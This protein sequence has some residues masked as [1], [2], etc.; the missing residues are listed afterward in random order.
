MEQR[1]LQ[2]RCRPCTLAGRQLITSQSNNLRCALLVP[3]CHHLLPLLGSFHRFLGLAALAAFLFCFW[4]LFHS[5][6]AP[7]HRRVPTCL[8]SGV[9]TSTRGGGNSQSSTSDPTSE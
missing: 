7:M 8:L 2:W 6:H 3:P 1:S 9:N 4:P 5:V